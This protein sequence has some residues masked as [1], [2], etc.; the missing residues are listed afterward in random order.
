M[1]W[2]P[3]VVCLNH[4]TKA[5]QREKRKECAIL[6]VNQSSIS[7]QTERYFIA[8][9]QRQIIIKFE[10]WRVKIK[11]FVYVQSLRNLPFLCFKQKCS[12]EQFEN[13]RFKK[14][15]TFQVRY[16]KTAQKLNDL[17]ILKWKTTSAN[18]SYV[19]IF[20]LFCCSEIL[21]ILRFARENEFQSIIIKLT[22]WKLFLKEFI[23]ETI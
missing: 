17:S 16:M 13:H 12:I 15:S 5:I 2:A 7:I 19:L 9:F 1:Y 4:S 18:C 6:S 21:Y 14:K 11:G 3:I 10:E 23:F 20:N 22:A 8:L